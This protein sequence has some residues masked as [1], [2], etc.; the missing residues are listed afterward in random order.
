MADRPIALAAVVVLLMGKRVRAYVRGGRPWGQGTMGASQLACKACEAMQGKAAGMSPHAG[1]SLVYRRK[2]GLAMRLF[3]VCRVC[4]TQMLC[5]Q[6]SA[7]HDAVWS[8]T[9]SG[10]PQPPVQREDI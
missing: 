5:R 8:V 2:E 10:N 3:Y 9:L 1:Q 7:E 4:D 6:G